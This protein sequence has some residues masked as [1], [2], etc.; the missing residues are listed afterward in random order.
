MTAVC[1]FF[2]E[3][4]SLCIANVTVN[5]LYRLNAWLLSHLME[6]LLNN[7]VMEPYKE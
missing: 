7:E 2:Y 1:I 5:I 6:A 3:C 4:I